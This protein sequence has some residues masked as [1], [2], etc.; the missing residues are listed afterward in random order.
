MP[1]TLF[2]VISIA[3]FTLADEVRQ[4]SFIIMFFVCALFIL[5]VRGCYRGE[6]VVNE[7]EI[8]AG[9]VIILVS[10]I[11]FHLIVGGVMFLAGLL[12]MRVFRRDRDDGTQSGVLSKP[13]QRW[14]YVAGK[15]AGLWILSFVFMFIL[16]A[17]VFGI[18]SLKMNTV[19][20]EYLLASVVASLNLLFVVV[21]VLLLSLAMPD[22][23]ALLCVIG[24]AL[25]GYMAD[26][27]FA[28][29]QSPM[30]QAMMQQ[31]L[32]SDPTFWQIIYSLW[33]KLSGVQGF[34]SSFIGANDAG[35]LAPVYPLLNVLLYCVILGALLFWRFRKEDIT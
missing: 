31:H 4:K 8:E 27:I 13:I 5:M 28:V 16:H 9:K 15:V 1:K 25:I 19:M 18:T 32:S 33:P 12:S 26:G 21:T 22:I 2:P 14:Q 10:K 11:T 6:Y 30:G 23:V 20:P 24:I 29:S 17:I 34:A 3:K 35:Q 7:R